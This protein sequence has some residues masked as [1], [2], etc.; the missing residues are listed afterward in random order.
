MSKRIRPLANATEKAI[1]KSGASSRSKARD[2]TLLG[3]SALINATVDRHQFGLEQGHERNNWKTGQNDEDFM[4]D[5]VNHF[6]EHAL[7][8][9]TGFHP[10]DNRPASFQDL[11]AAICNLNMI[12][13]NAETGTGLATAFP[14]LVKETEIEPTSDRKGR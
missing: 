8:I 9:V 3:G 5:R 7:A 13:N 10:R 6:F 12:I 14:Y 2:Y 4:R 1:F 11:Q